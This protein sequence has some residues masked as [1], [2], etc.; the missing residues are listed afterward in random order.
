MTNLSAMKYYGG[1]ARGRGRW[2][3]SH[4]PPETNCLYVEPFAGML[5]VLLNRPRAYD[6]IVGDADGRIVNWWRVVRDNTAELERL[7][8]LTPHSRAEFENALPIADDPIEDAR[9]LTILILQSLMHGTNTSRGTYAI[10]KR[11]NS[12]GNSDLSRIAGRLSALAERIRYIQLNNRD[13]IK[14]LEMV[15]SVTNAVVYCDPPYQSSDISLYT[16][17]TI[18]ID[19]MTAALL[20]Q[21]GRVAVSGYGD[22]WEHL[23]WRC[24]EWETC[25]HAGGQPGIAQGRRIEKLWMNYP[26]FSKQGVLL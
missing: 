17:G 23:G 19:A 15:A 5:G 26:P 11:G 10:S 3:L 7:L 9:R 4:L 13:G 24:E 18:D 20:A 25:S 16:H 21:R 6:E 14:T 1:K 12:N 22:E 2:V 8:L